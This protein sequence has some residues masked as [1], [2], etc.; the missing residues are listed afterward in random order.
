M[1]DTSTV[2]WWMDLDIFCDTCGDADNYEGTDFYDAL[3]E[4][5]EDGWKIKKL[6]GEWKHYCPECNEIED[7]FIL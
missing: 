2:Y 7:S 4:A 1:I 5:R 3:K 6:F